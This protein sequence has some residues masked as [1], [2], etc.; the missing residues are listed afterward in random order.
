MAKGQK[1]NPLKGNQSMVVHSEM[2]KHRNGAE[3]A[4]VDRILHDTKKLIFEKE[5]H[6]YERNCYH[7][8]DI[9]MGGLEA[10]IAKAH[11]KKQEQSLCQNNLPQHAV[12]QLIIKR[13]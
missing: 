4:A 11:N 9:F 7:M 5:T 6:A 3:M 10:F 2:R 8:H 13:A 12:L 1:R